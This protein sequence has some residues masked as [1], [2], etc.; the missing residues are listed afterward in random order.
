MSEIRAT[1]ISNLA[2]TGPA[3]LTGQYA[4]KVFLLYDQITN[5]I[6]NSG[7][8]SSVIDNTTGEFTQN[9]AT[10]FDAADYSLAGTCTNISAAADS[11]FSLGPLDGGTYT[12]SATRVSYGNRGGAID[13]DKAATHVIGDLA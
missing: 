11:V 10:S 2:G 8:I 5:V 3:T 13:R 4:A 7:N 6:T 1:T 9:Y 12:A